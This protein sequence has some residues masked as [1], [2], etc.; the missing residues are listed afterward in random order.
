MAIDPGTLS[1]IA[2]IGSGLLGAY[3][4][5]QTAG[6]VTDANR[7][8]IEA[9]KER[10]EKGLQALTG[11]D[12]FKTI[13]R[14]GGG[15]N[16]SQPGA[17]DAAEARSI[18]AFGDIDRAVKSNTATRDFDFKLP[19]I[20]SAQSVID[21]GIAG[22]QGTVDAGV[23]KLLNLKKR[24]FG[25]LNHSGM[26]GSTVDA[27][28][29][30]AG[31]NSADRRLNALELFDKSK[32]NDLALQSQILANLSSRAGAPAFTSGGPG[33]TAAQL[34]AQTPQPRQVADL[35]GGAALGAAGAQTLNQLSNQVRADENN[36]LIRDILARHLGDD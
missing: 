30:F 12:A 32:Q 28:A 13:T 22:R 9:S 7:A 24:Q 33:A 2:T 14:D 15:F 6:A 35:S 21:E 26:G 34:I 23:N 4:A 16:V 11:S 25:G 36:R 19:T 27:L 10:Q 31:E 3:G 17:T 20:G 18:A 29:R 5:N 1:L 8:S